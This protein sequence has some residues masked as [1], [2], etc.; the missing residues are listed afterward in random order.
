MAARAAKNKQSSDYDDDSDNGGD[1][2]DDNYEEEQQRE[3]KRRTM[4]FG[5]EDSDESIVE[6]KSY[7]T[8]KKRGATGGGNKKKADGGRSRNESRAGRGNR[9]RAAN[10]PA[11]SRSQQM[12]NRVREKLDGCEGP[13]FTAQTMSR[14]EHLLASY[15]EP[16]GSDTESVANEK[17]WPKVVPGLFFYTEQAP[18]AN[19]KGGGDFL[20]APTIHF[21]TGSDATNDILSKELKKRGLKREYHATYEGLKQAVFGHE[22]ITEAQRNKIRKRT[23]KSKAKNQKKGDDSDADE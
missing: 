13:L 7:Q 5:N 15:K 19:G 23:L 18:N 11:T 9:K 8:K 16:D 3:R 14:P 6:A 12:D 21:W 20:K 1:D 22:S 17:R 2:D 10:T 4:I